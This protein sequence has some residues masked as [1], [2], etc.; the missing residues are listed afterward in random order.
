MLDKVEQLERGFEERDTKVTRIVEQEQMLNHSELAR[1]MDTAQ[2][3][4]LLTA[5]TGKFI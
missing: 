2:P 1:K 4:S 5:D 3:R